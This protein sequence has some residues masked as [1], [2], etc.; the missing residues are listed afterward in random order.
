LK[1]QHSARHPI[2][3]NWKFI[4][5]RTSRFNLAGNRNASHPVNAILNYAYAILQSQL[6]IQAISEGYDPTLGIMH[7]RN[8]GSPAFIFDLM[9]PERSKIDRVIIEFLKSE[10]LHPADFVIRGDG[11]VRL[12]PEMARMVVA[13]VST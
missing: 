4:G 8:P 1:W 5:S 11:V 3:D 2:P 6:Q 10:K 13:R 12:N 9:E 7:F